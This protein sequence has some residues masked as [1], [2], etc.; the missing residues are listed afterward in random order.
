MTWSFGKRPFVTHAWSVST[1]M[2]WNSVRNGEWKPNFGKRRASGICPPSKPARYLL[3]EREPAPLEPRV[4]VLP[5]PEPSPRPTRL[6]FLF[7]PVAGRGL[8]IAIVNSFIG[9]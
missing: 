4:E 1:L 6:R 3:P 9:D 7:A 5:C 8:L 2:I